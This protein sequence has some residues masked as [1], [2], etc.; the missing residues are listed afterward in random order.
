MTLTQ[1]GLPRAQPDASHERRV[2]G[3]AHAKVEWMPYWMVL[4][5]AVAIAILL[6]YPLV[7]LVQTS[8]QQYNLVTIF[9][10]KTVW[11]GIAN[12]TSIFSNGSFW[13]SVWRTFAFTGAC[14]AIK[15]VIG[16]GVALLMLRLGKVVR[17]TVSVALIA[18]WAMPPI[19]AAIVWQ[20]LFSNQ[21]GVVD[22]ILSALGVGNF[23]NLDWFA[24]NPLRA[25][26]VITM[27]IVWNSVPFV[28]LCLYSG[29]V[30]VPSELYEAAR[31]D[32]ATGWRTLRDITLPLIK[33]IAGLVIVLSFIW[34]FNIFAG[35]WVLTQGGPNGSTET[36]GV[37]SYVEAFSGNQFGLGAAASVVSMVIVGVMSA[38]YVRGLIRSGQVK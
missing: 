3:R 20:W 24:T 37:W 6:G 15:M 16:T 19:T 10:H 1:A 26:S 34:D 7:R 30:Q 27:M 38:Y 17:T 31:V 18:V 28:A 8:L 11:D 14:L 13:G 9:S 21:F 4:P 35:I 33:P 23:S 29:L 5:S 32:G 2:L 25:W 36:I 12:Y 22:W